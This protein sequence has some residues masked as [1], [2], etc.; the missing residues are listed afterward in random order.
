M[1]ICKTNFFYYNL[2]FNPKKKTINLGTMCT[3]IS[4]IH[5]NYTPIYK[6]LVHLKKI[7][8]CKQCKKCTYAALLQQTKDGLSISVL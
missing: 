1:Y 4:L 8:F 5:Y 3:H 6:T 2:F 7:K